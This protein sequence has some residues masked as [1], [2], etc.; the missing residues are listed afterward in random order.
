MENFEFYNPVKVIFGAGEASR[1]GVEAAK[2]GHSA[3]V[4]SYKDAGP[5]AGLLSQIEGQLKAAKMSVATSYQ[6]TAN[7]RMDEVCAGVAAAK[8]AKAD[9]IIG[10]GGGSAMDVAKL[11][12]AGVPYQG[13]VR[14]MLVLRHDQSAARLPT[15][16]LPM[17]MVPLAAWVTVRV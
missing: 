5:L 13:D 8:A 10:V 3:L 4:V 9:V 12:A 15:E 11:V 16:A 17:L 2:L 7:P 6:M 14:D 1:T